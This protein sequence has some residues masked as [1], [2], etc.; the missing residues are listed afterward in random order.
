MSLHV[1]HVDA[2]WSARSFSFLWIK[3]IYIGRGFDKLPVHVRNAVF[4]HERYHVD[5]HHTEIRMLAALAVLPLLW[6]KRICHA[7]EFAADRWVAEV[8]FRKGLLQL[9]AADSPESLTHPSHEARRAQLSTDPRK[10]PPR[11]VGVTG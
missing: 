9:L 10:G 8:G 6:I 7:Q 3:R 4:A 2:P 11:V 5:H 1:V